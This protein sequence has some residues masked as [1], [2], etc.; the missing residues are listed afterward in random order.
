MITSQFSWL[1]VA[2][3]NSGWSALASVPSDVTSDSY[4]PR[5]SNGH[6]T[7]TT[8]VMVATAASTIA[9]IVP[10]HAQWVLAGSRVQ[11][12]GAGALAPVSECQLLVEGVLHLLPPGAAPLLELDSMDGIEPCHPWS[13]P[14]SRTRLPSEVLTVVTMVTMFHNDYNVS[15]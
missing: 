14:P 4:A 8:T 7:I 1:V 2:M 3:A 5:E 11:E 15:Q 12:R 9:T 10:L 13:R 6:P